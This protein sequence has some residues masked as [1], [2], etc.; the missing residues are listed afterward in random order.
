MN[1]LPSVPDAVLQHVNQK[2]VLQ[3]APEN[4]DT[5]EHPLSV[6]SGCKLERSGTFGIVDEHDVRRQSPVRYVLRE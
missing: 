1:I 4:G 5:P 6:E 3:C 2:I